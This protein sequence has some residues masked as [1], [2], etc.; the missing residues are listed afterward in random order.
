LAGKRDVIPNRV[1]VTWIERCT[2]GDEGSR[3]LK[4]GC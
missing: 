1:N 4:P 2:A 3:Y